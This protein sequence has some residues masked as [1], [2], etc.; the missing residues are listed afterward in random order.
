MLELVQLRRAIMAGLG[1][2]LL[3][4]V[5]PELAAAAAHLDFASIQRRHAPTRLRNRSLV[6]GVR[7]I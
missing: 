6:A 3:D 1:L 4:E 7:E 5:G 2:L